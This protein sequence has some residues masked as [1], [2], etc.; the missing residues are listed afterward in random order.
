MLFYRNMARGTLDAKR[1]FPMKTTW[2]FYATSW[3]VPLNVALLMLSA[4]A[5]SSACDG[6]AWCAWKRTWHAPY[7]LTTPL[8]GYYIPRQPGHCSVA[9]YGLGD[10]Y[11]IECG[12][13]FPDALT[14]PGPSRRTFDASP[15]TAGDPCDP[16]RSE[17]L[18]QIPN[19]LA[20]TLEGPAPAPSR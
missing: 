1:R 20:I 11:A 6:S 4:P 7:A 16:V 9:D 5:Y 18:G 13:A 3:L 15:M 8:R 19:D 2:P 14:E 17:R 10:G 12:Y